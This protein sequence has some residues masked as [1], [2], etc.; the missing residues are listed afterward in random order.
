M[1]LKLGVSQIFDCLKQIQIIQI[2]IM[3]CFRFEFS[4]QHCKGE[5]WSKPVQGLPGA[6][7]DLDPSLVS[8]ANLPQPKKQGTR[9]HTLRTF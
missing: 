4:D 5:G 3:N 2:Q 9:T 8:A 1:S 6:R 7:P